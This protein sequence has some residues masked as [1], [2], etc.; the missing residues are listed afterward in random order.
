MTQGGEAA[1]ARGRAWL[2]AAPLPLVLV[3]AFA[4]RLAWAWASLDRLVRDATSDDAYYYF[5]IAREL[6]RTGRASFDGETLTNGFHPLWLACVTAVQA[7][8]AD[9]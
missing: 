6:A 8:G 3:T 5:A 9:P 2:R 1:A 7:L 4:L